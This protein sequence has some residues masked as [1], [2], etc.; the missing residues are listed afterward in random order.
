MGAAITG[1]EV[2]V[3]AVVDPVVLGAE[4]DRLGD[5]EAAVGLDLDV[6]E[7]AQNALIRVRRGRECGEK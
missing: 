6:A 5:F 4:V 2:A 1:R 7:I 3:D